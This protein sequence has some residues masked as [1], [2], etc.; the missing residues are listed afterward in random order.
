[1]TVT[2][3]IALNLESVSSARAAVDVLAAQCLIFSIPCR[4]PWSG[5]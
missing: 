2:G 5:R 3:K 1:M 4:S